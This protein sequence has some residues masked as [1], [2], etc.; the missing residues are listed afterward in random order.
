M[1]GVA[2]DLKVLVTILSP[3]KTNMNREPPEP[4]H[5]PSCASCKPDSKN[6]DKGGKTSWED[7]HLFQRGV[8]ADGF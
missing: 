3:Q 4:T 7:P 1:I 8:V 5:Q 2:Y 6:M